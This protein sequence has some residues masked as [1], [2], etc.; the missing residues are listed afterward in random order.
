MEMFKLS[1][2]NLL[3]FFIAAQISIR[4]LQL[5]KGNIIYK[6]QLS[7]YI[8][9]ICCTISLCVIAYDILNIGFFSCI[10]IGMFIIINAIIGTWF[11]AKI[12]SKSFLINTLLLLIGIFLDIYILYVLG[13]KLYSTSIFWA[14]YYQNTPMGAPF[15]KKYLLLSNTE[16]PIF[17][18][19]PS[20]EY[21]IKET[22]FS[23][24]G[25]KKTY[26]Q[27][28]I[29]DVT[30]Y[31]ITP[32]TQEDVLHKVQKL[33]D[34]IGQKG[35]G[36]IYFP[37][38]KY[39][40][41]KNSQKRGFLQI[42]YS[43]IHITGEISP[44]GT[45][46]TILENCNHTVSGKQNPWL[47]PFFITTGEVIQKSNIFFGLQ[48]LNKK[49]IITKSFS[50]TDP[51]SDGTILTPDFATNIIAD[52]PKGTSLITVEDSSIFSH[53][54][55]IMIG[56]YNTTP[57]G[58]LIKDILGVNELLPEWGTACRAGEEQAPSYQWLVEVSEIIDSQTIKLSRPLLRDIETK[59]TPK[60]FIVP[61][62]ED[63]SI[64][65]LIIS[66][67]W[68]GLFRHHGQRKYYSIQQA[69]EM[70]YG[71]NGINMK[72]VTHGEI[73]NII[74][75]NHTNPLYIMDSRNITIKNIEIKGADGH[76]GIKIYEHAC[77]NL[78]QNIRFYNH[79]ADMVGGEGN[80]Y[81]NVFENITYSNPYFKPADYDFHGFS[82]GPMSPPSHNLFINCYGFRNVKGAGSTYNQPACAQ[83]N[84]W[85]NCTRIGQ[86][87]GEAFFYNIHYKNTLPREKHAELFK[88]SIVR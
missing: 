25:K 5:L 70:D 54:R 14:I 72:R 48:F 66:S 6:K 19:N 55:Y 61:M 2:I 50:M 13:Y 29:F 86:K 15:L 85:I 4:D 41:N 1:L 40:F 78:F 35:G 7:S 36:E 26:S 64:S 76:Q 33:I 74:L 24:A 9:Y 8:T 62:L 80:A 60:I 69:K 87:K 16:K 88:N 63:V 56:L 49:N 43:H 10:P 82:E 18:K 28:P 34:N 45:P 57:D 47:S 42:N 23:F 37:K 12:N 53:N 51:G 79:Y 32:D 73:H 59:Y 22:D 11:I 31:G 38:G 17:I 84:A 3:L 46:L 27:L 52:S 65:N 81:G 21:I 68:N 44:D 58:N 39:L 75:K 30:Q 67:K 83:Y 77:D 71:W 20:N